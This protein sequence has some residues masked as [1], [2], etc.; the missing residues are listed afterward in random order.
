MPLSDEEY[1]DYVLIIWISEACDDLISCERVDQSG[2]VNSSLSM[3][4]FIALMGGKPI[5]YERIPNMDATCVNKPELYNGM[6]PVYYEDGNWKIADSTNSNESMVWYDYDDSKW[7]N[8][9]FVNTDEYA[10]SDEGTII[11]QEDILGYYVWIPRFKYKL[12]NDG[13]NITDSYNA[14]KNGIDIV[15]ESGINSSD[16][17]K[18]GDSKCIYE[19]NKYLTH[20]A[21]ADNLRGFWISKYE[22]SEGN[23]FIPNVESLKNESLDSYKNIISGLSTTYNLSDT[24]DSHIVTN[25]EWGAALYLSHSKYGVCSSDGCKDISANAT[26]ISESNKQD[27]TTRNVYGVYDMAGATPEYAVGSFAV[28]TAI[29]EV[30]ITD[31]TTWYN[32]NYLAINND[33][34]LRGGMERGLFFT[35]DIGMYDVST[36]SVLV[37]KEKEDLVVG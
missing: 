4:V 23:K 33:Y 37:S 13:I 16:T 9:V 31:S 17:V 35:S 11:S 8:A 34:I 2:I 3:K 28:G 20:P 27:T 19:K 15:F 18:C 30:R 5:D 7:A 36:R 14:Y 22:I 1:D 24:V 32:G 12:W 10:E 29:E 26:Y 21:F 6:I 25:L